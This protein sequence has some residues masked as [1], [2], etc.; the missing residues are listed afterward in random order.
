MEDIKKLIDK[1]LIYA[2]KE[3]YYAVNTV[4]AYKKDIDKYFSFIITIK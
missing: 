3:K 2:K 1:W 4:V